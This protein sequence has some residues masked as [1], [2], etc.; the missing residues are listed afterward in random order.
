MGESGRK[1][2]LNL[3]RTSLNLGVPM[4][5]SIIIPLFNRLDLT[6]V[7]LDTLGQTT[8]RLRCEVILVDDGSSD[9]TREFLRGIEGPARR[10]I[11]NDRPRGYAANNNAAARLARAPIL[12]LLNNDTALLPGWLEEMLRVLARARAAGCVGN[13][14]REPLCGLI[15]HIGITFNAAGNPVHAGKDTPSPPLARYT[16]WPAVT[17][18]CCV[19]R[20]DLFERLGGLDESFSN[21]FEDVDFCLRAAEQGA[22]HYVANRSVIYH[23]ISASPGRHRREA[24][25][26]KVFRERWGWRVSAYQE[27]CAAA[28]LLRP[29]V[30]P[31]TAEEWRHAW[32]QAREARRTQRQTIREVRK[33]GRRYLRKHLLR[34]W[35]YN[36]ARLCDALAQAT[37]PLRPALRPLRVGP[38]AASPG[39]SIEDAW[40]FDPPP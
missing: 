11:L 20:R 16:R 32:R 17:A 39:K 12:C 27:R 35:R 30:S 24:E 1:A 25:N 18:A 28:G 29:G 37:H 3:G 7:C 33:E 26:L 10:V 4:D 15:D 22:A 40:L 5:V 36:Y 9:G 21:G 14:Q 38:V 23:H 8:A 2:R 13:I 19:V 34:P 6:R 31:Q